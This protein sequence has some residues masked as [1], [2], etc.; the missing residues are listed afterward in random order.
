VFNTDGWR[1][2]LFDPSVDCGLFAAPDKEKFPPPIHWGECDPLLASTGWTC[3]QLLFDWAPPAGIPTS[4]MMEPVDDGWLDDSGRPWLLVSRNS[5]SRRFRLV[6]EADGPIHAAFV[7]TI[8]TSCTGGTGRLGGGHFVYSAFRRSG[9]AN[10]SVFW[11]AIGGGLDDTPAVLSTSASPRGYYS[12]STSYVESPENLLLPWQGTAPTGTPLDIPDPGLATDYVFGRS[13][14]FFQ[15]ANQAYHRIKIY[16][17]GVG[18]QEFISFGDTVSSGAADFGTDGKDMVW[19]EASGRTL[20]TDPWT[21]INIMTA[22]YTEDQK[23][24]VKRRVRSEVI[25][26]GAAPFKVGC[27]FAAH[28]VGEVGPRLLRLSDGRS[29]QFPLIDSAVG[30]NWIFNQ[31]L[32]VSCDEVFVGAYRGNQNYLVRIRIDSLGPG[33]PPD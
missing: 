6:A 1:S 4:T 23:A 15:V 21:T 24:I 9:A 31:I 28:F 14:I 2:L 5:G 19:T 29:W 26:I 11:G 32:G 30:Y 12:G 3:R 8:P 7:E 25:S 27:G 13:A 20:S 16:T 22:K 17:S 33:I 10:A 18:V